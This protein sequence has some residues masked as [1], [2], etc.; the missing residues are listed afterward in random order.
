MNTEREAQKSY[1]PEFK[2]Q[3]AMELLAGS[4]TLDELA[5]KY[6]IA[7]SILNEWC[8]TVKKRLPALF[9]IQQKDEQIER[10]EKEADQLTLERNWLEKM[11]GELA[12]N[13][14]VRHTGTLRRR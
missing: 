5:A 3:V 12:R 11:S 1:T 8:E 13:R 7:P 6:Q 10:L 14:M 9:E 4:T 2:A